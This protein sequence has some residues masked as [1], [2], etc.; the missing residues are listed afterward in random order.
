MFHFLQK[1]VFHHHHHG[2]GHGHGH[3]RGRGPKMFDAG[4]LRYVVLQLIAEKPRHGY[5][6]IK[7]LEQRAGAGYT[8]SP[9][10]IYPLLA[11]LADMGHVAV[12]AD[13]NKKLHTITP[14]GEAFLNENRAMV[15]ALMGRM[16][17]QNERGA[18]ELRGLMYE[19]KL[20]VVGKARDS[21]AT[22]ERLQQIAAILRA[23]AADI[24]QLK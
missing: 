12:T 1:H 8:P 6:I 23:A 11:M 18:D 17:A 2:M 16:S 21:A 15:D 9:G 5:D 7:E 19:L 10:A 14:E 24:N 3:G 4:A 22:P 20:A 13:G